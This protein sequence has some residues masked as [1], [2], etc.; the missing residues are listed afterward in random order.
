MKAIMLLGLITLYTLGIGACIQC[1]CPAQN[2]RIPTATNAPDTQSVPL[3][4]LV[5]AVKQGHVNRIEVHGDILYYYLASNDLRYE[6]KLEKGTTVY[7]VLK[8][9]GI[10]PDDSRYPKIE[11]L[12]P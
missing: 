11:V 1:D 2:T 9:N 8:D 10:A 4:Q 7:E 12:V 3:G 6:T 5:E